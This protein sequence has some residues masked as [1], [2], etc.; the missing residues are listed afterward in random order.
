MKRILSAVAG[1]IG[2]IAGAVIQPVSAQD[3][4]MVTVTDLRGTAV[5]VPAEPRRIATV[6]FFGVDT[7]LA[8]GLKPV[9]TTYMTAGRHPEYLLGLTKDMQMLGQRA[10][11]NLEL[12]S[13]A[14]PDLIIAIPRYVNANIAQFRK[15]APV[16]AY[17]NELFESD[18]AEVENLGKVLGK[19]AEAKA[20]NERFEAD[21]A[22]YAA[23]AP[24]DGRPRFQIMWAGDTPYSFYTG[25]MTA[26]IVATLAGKNIAGPIPPGGRFGAELSLENMLDEDPEVIFVYD[27]GP[28]RPHEAN[29]IWKRIS[30]VKNGRVYYVGDHWVEASG[31]IARQIVLREAAGL[32]YPAVFPKVDVKAEARK[33]IPANLQER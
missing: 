30:A 13:Q 11:P 2:L 20:L 29:P 17:D 19:E 4:K 1:A 23:R 8:L 7:A 18:A 33:I 12:F 27:S 21:L 28:D 25:H 24:K 9:A 6:S 5:S 15:I 31:P 3:I 26:S 14:R 32:L 16:I 10:K 22:D